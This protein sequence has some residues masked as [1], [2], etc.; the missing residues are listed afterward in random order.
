MYRGKR[1]KRVESI[2]INMYPSQFSH[3]I[4]SLLILLFGLFI[5]CF[6]RKAWE[7]V[8][9][10]K[11]T[12]FSIF[13]YILYFIIVLIVKEYALG[14]EDAAVETRETANFI[15]HFFRWYSAVALVA[16]NIYPKY[17]IFWKRSA[18]IKKLKETMSSNKVEEGDPLSPQ[19]PRI[20]PR[21]L[22]RPSSFSTSMIDEETLKRLKETVGATS[23]GGGGS[24]PLSRKN[25]KTQRIS[26]INNNTGTGN[27]AWTVA[28]ASSSSSTSAAAHPPTS[29]S[30]NSLSVA[31][32]GAH[33]TTNRSNPSLSDRSSVGG[34]SS[35]S[36]Q[37]YF[38]AAGRRPSRRPSVT[39][40]MIKEISNIREILN[41]DHTNNNIN[42]ANNAGSTSSLPPPGPA[43]RTSSK[44]SMFFFDEKWAMSS[45]NCIRD[46]E[47]GDGGGG[48][49]NG[50]GG[51]E[52]LASDGFQVQKS[53]GGTSPGAR[54]RSQSSSAGGCGGAPSLSHSFL[55]IGA[56]SGFSPRK[57]SQSHYSASQPA[58]QVLSTD[59]ENYPPLPIIKPRPVS[60]FG[61]EDGL[62]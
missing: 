50:G 27:L 57:R 32:T 62:Y 26:E 55:S 3:T 22:R 13:N 10:W 52:S 8:N 11:S 40:P 18:Q 38:Q 43:T 12:F 36:R 58:P 46:N 33:I 20:D 15:I 30:N 51:E 37:N 39:I 23:S 14:G 29:A 47:T 44:G 17:E 24:A 21:L 25:S 16:I 7:N 60:F 6:G 53:I 49:Q 41:G 56:S 54:K 31:L 42:D 45:G 19:Q 4:L 5:G 48:K 34:S 28:A 59:G 9:I 2:Y 35:T 1:W 61:M